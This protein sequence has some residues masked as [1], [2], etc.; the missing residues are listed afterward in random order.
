[1]IRYWPTSEAPVIGTRR[2]KRYAIAKL[3]K[4]PY[5]GTYKIPCK[6]KPIVMIDFAGEKVQRGKDQCRCEVKLKHGK[7][8]MMQIMPK[9][10]NLL[11]DV[12]KHHYKS[13]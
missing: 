10:L 11:G 4:G 12:Q 13:K 1:M 2:L 8:S 5:Q 6:R 9:G 3:C 7:N